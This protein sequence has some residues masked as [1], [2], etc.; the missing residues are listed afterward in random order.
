MSTP[1]MQ[2]ETSK[3]SVK[4]GSTA[5]GGYVPEI[6]VYEDTTAEELERIR[7]MAVEAYVLTQRDL[8]IAKAASQRQTEAGP[9]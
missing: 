6:K 2:T 4:I 7:R 3:S 9:S 8:A 1:E 5:A